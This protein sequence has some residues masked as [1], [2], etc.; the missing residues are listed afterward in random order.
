M[1]FVETSSSTG[2]LEL[3]DSA[4]APDAVAPPQRL[5]AWECFKRYKFG[6]YSLIAFLSLYGFSLAGALFFNDRPLFVYYEHHVYLPLL[7]DYP[8]A[9]FGG[10]LPIAAD[11]NDPFIRTQISSSGNFALYPI[12]SYR[13]DT[14]DYFT[15]EKHHPG[16]PNLRNWLGTDTSG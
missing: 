12:H 11:Y 5:T 1:A 13:Y 2:E 4:P 9:T 15:I 8:E 3:L 16:K 14:L 6:Y 10:D 7:R